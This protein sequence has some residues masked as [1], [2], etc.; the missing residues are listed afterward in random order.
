MSKTFVIHVHSGQGPLHYDLMLETAGALAT[1]RLERCPADLAPGARAEAKRLADHRAAY[2]TY[3]GPV[4][5]DRGWV[6]RL[7]GGTCRLLRA[8]ADRWTVEF[9][10]G[11]LRGAFEL[12][13]TGP[14][15]DDWQLVCLARPDAPTGPS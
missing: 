2:L 6:T 14:D 4:S 3:E 10:G 15:I 8:E 13:Q 1:W 11:R 5:G 12:R 7:D 9:A